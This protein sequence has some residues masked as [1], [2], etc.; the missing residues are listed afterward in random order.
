MSPIGPSRVTGHATQT[1][2]L[3]E[4]FPCSRPRA[5]LTDSSAVEAT[6]TDALNCNILEL[7][8]QT[9]TSGADSGDTQTSGLDK[10]LGTQSPLEAI[11]PGGSTPS[12]RLLF[13]ST[14]FYTVGL[15]KVA[16]RQGCLPRGTKHIAGYNP[17]TSE[18]I[19]MPEL[20]MHRS[21]GWVGVF[22]V[23]KRMVR[24]DHCRCFQL[25]STGLFGCFDWLP[26]ATDCAHQ[27]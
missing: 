19:P 25:L 14:S 17:C 15:C 13:M 3:S 11:L 2:G 5:N 10:Y 22:M 8:W 21:L 16:H 23:P 1:L 24:K 12:S 27:Q 6:G 26:Q 20:P 9:P 4:L 7:H 18:V